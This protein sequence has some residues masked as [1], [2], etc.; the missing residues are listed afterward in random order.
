MRVC[1]VSAGWRSAAAA[2]RRHVVT[3]RG[4]ERRGGGGG[5]GTQRFAPPERLLSLA[6]GAEQVRTGQNAIV[7]VCPSYLASTAALWHLARRLSLL[8]ARCTPPNLA[9]ADVTA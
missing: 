9:A 2:P 3:A 8:P 6:P 7:L 1:D 4:G 5:A